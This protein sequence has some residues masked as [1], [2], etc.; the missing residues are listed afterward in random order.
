[1][2][3]GGILTSSDN[4]FRWISITYYKE[5]LT[6]KSQQ[7]RDQ[8][9]DSLNPPYDDCSDSDGG[10]EDI[11]STIISCGDTAPVFEPAEH[12]LDLMA[13]FVLNFAEES[14]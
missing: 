4:W 8:A 2:F 1:M 7:C 9:Q 3:E 12:V 14:G 11:S 10:H 13:L 6:E 5:N